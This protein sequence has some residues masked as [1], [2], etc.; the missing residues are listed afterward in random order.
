VSRN[1]AKNVQLRLPGKQE[2]G[3]STNESSC[4]WKKKGE[5]SFLRADEGRKD[6]GAN[7]KGEEERTNRRSFR[8]SSLF[9]KKKRETV[10]RY[11]EE[12]T[13]ASPTA[14]KRKKLLHVFQSY[15]EREILVSFDQRVPFGVGRKKNIDRPS[16]G[17]KRV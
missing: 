14:R 15:G 1:Q 9:C 6:S 17:R 3:E 13:G 8:A 7:F 12:K 10:E 16:Q 5:E 11:G 4:S 2:V